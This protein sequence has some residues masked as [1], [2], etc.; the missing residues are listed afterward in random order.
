[1]TDFKLAIAHNKGS[2]S[3]VWI[4]YCQ[5]NSIDYKLVDCYST[6]IM[7]ELKECDALM[8]H[9]HHNDHKA[10]LF[11]RQLTYSLE[12]VGKKL[13]PDTKTVWHFDDKVG[14][15]Y[16]L[17]AIEAPMVKSYVF[18]TKESAVK[19]A[20]NTDYPKVYKLRGGAGASNVRLIRDK[21]SA[22]RYI[23]RAF[24]R[25]FGVNRFS[26][27]KERW[28]QVRRDKT[29][30]SLINLLKSIGRI[31]I[32]NSRLANMPIDKNYIYAQDFIPGSDSD[33][34]VVIIGNRALAIK[35]MVRDGDF[36]A[37]GSGNFIFDPACI[38]MQCIETAF[39]TSKKLQSQSVAYDFIISNSQP[40][41]IE[42]SYAFTHSVFLNCTGYWSNNLQWQESKICPAMFMIEDL[43]N[44]LRAENEPS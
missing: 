44:D 9:W 17:E 16:L 35:R 38:P 31:I 5:D 3:D 18:Y 36:R 40:L 33:I 29:V 21:S 1:M 41:I 8:W 42:I 32:P 43:I 14:Q 30:Q 37:S 6:T 26:T 27:F 11:A 10:I 20:K 34:R 7:E 25:G 28:W 13:F 15:K 4:E 39:K 23:K 2:F 22:L 12:L 19:W 24:G